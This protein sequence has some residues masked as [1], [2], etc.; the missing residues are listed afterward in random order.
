MFIRQPEYHHPLLSDSFVQLMHPN[1]PVNHKTRA[2]FLL[3]PTLPPKILSHSSL[4]QTRHGGGGHANE[5]EGNE[6]QDHQR[7]PLK[8]AKQ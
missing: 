8:A 7:V 3:H 1:L 5:E 4:C 6:L 2:R